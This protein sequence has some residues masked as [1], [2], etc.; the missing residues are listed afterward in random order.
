MQIVGMFELTSASTS[1]MPPKAQLMKAKAAETRMVANTRFLQQYY[2]GR[3][4][5]VFS[6]NL[7]SE[8]RGFSI[9]A[10]EIFTEAD[11][12]PRQHESSDDF[13]NRAY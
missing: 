12:E 6:S 9:S 8:G 7:K 4:I 5:C 10:S 3:G 2:Y 13:F 1:C 11:D